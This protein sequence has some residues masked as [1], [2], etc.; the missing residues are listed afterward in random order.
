MT[1]ANLSVDNRL[2]S[3]SQKCVEYVLKTYWRPVKKNVLSWWYLLKTF[4]SCLEN[5]F[6]RRLEYIWPR[7]IYSSWS[8]RLLKMKMKTSSRHLQ[9]VFIKVW[10]TSLKID[11]VAFLFFFSSNWLWKNSLKKLSKHFNQSYGSPIF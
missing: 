1:Y 11:L 10:I 7:R 9:E 6:T 5:V 3:T 4:W 2:H 8:R